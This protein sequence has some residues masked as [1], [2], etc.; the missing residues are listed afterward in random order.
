MALSIVIMKKIPESKHEIFESLLT[1]PNVSSGFGIGIGEIFPFLS[2]NNQ[3]N[4]I[5]LSEQNDDFARNIGFCLGHFMASTQFSNNEH[6]VIGLGSGSGHHFPYFDEET[7]G[8]I[9]KKAL[10]NK[11]FGLGFGLGLAKSFNQ[12]DEILEKEILTQ[13][14]IDNKFSYSLGYGL[15]NTFTSHS[16]NLQKKFLQ[17]IENQNFF[18]KG[19]LDGV[20][21]N[22]KYIDKESL[23][24]IFK[25]L[26]K[27]RII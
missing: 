27:N 26:E 10:T 3:N 16:G 9:L 1:N 5:N 6:F 24:Q 2:E 12:L 19:F 4:L 11:E 8:E 21:P 20:R 14:S 25:I 17:I 18:S 23:T 13:C 15:G 22:L 7:Q